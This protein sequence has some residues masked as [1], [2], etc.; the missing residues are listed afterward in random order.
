MS[1]AQWRRA[2]LAT[3]QIDDTGV[4][5]VQ[6]Y[7]LVNVRFVRRCRL[8]WHYLQLYIF[9][10]TVKQ[11]RNTSLSVAVVRGINNKRGT[12]HQSS[13]LVHICSLQ[14]HCQAE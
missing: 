3:E 9:R 8:N 10:Y 1:T 14:A 11:V 13:V 4:G 12:I 7:G 6:Y 2:V 5:A